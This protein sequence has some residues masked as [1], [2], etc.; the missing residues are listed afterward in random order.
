MDPNAARVLLSRVVESLLHIRRRPQM[1]FSPVTP[2]TVK[3]WLHGLQVGIHIAG[4]KCSHAAYRVAC[5]RRGIELP[6]TTNLIA[7][8][9]RQGKSSEE[10]AMA[11]IEI[12]E[13]MWRERL[14]ELA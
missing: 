2:E 12:E 11:L 3:Y 5:A 1:Y 14:A 4:V 9:G 8:L 6:A 13:E 7:E 10:V